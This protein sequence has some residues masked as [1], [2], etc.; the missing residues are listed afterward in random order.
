MN[1]RR[2][3]LYVGEILKILSYVTISSSLVS[4]I[5]QEWFGVLAFLIGFISF[6]IASYL[7]KR[8]GEQDK[9]SVSDSMAIATTSWVLTGLLGS[10]PFLI[11]AWTI[12]FNIEILGTPGMNNT[13]VAFLNPINGIFES[14][15][16]FTSTGLTF[17]AD[18]QQLPK[19]FQWWRSLTE[20]IGG[21][22]VIVLTVAVLARPGSGSLT[23]YNSEAREEKILPSVTSTVRE[24]WKIYT[25]L[26]ILFIIIFFLAG[27]KPWGAINH[28]MTALSTGGFSIYPDSIGH[29]DSAI[30]EYTVIP[31][32]IAG[33]IAFP[34]YYLMT[35]GE[36][37][38]V[39]KDTQTRWLII[40]FLTGSSI[41]IFLLLIS[42]QYG[43]LEESFR[44]G[45]FQFV[46]ATTNTGF[47]TTTIGTGTASVWS[48]SSMLFICLGMITGGS[49]GSTTSGIKIIRAYLLIKGT[50]WQIMSAIRPKNMVRT[51]STGKREMSSSEFNKE[52]T[53]ATVII[54]L[55]FVVAFLSTLLLAIIYPSS[56]P[57]ENIVFE[58]L[59]SQNN[60]GVN[61]GIIDSDVHVVAKIIFIFT[62]L[63]GRLEIVPVAVV[64]TKIF[65]FTNSYN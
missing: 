19:S 14:V 18:E 43:S 20:W 47:G 38:K 51:F 32:M 34:I 4:I 11:M 61:A 16:G 31:A 26:T 60:V 21:V 49:S 7:M 48:I 29:Y 65:D 46:S 53:E 9:P 17:A 33:S 52:Y 45:L 12:N 42:D 58:V 5:F 36:I 3:S 56:I 64:V 50:I 6:Y 10:V 62:M 13:L 28:A 2:I 23:L 15:S 55:W 1:P 37:K 40:W 63:V 35:Q 59:S 39:Y 57:L 25:S 8:V 24:I 30:I 27:M 44:A 22:G 41:L 54:I